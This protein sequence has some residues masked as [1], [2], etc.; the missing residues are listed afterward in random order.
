MDFVL[1]ADVI[2][3]AVIV[4][5]LVAGLILA[6]VIVVVE[7]LVLRL[8]RWAPLGRSFAD[9]VVANVVSAVVGVALAIVL[10]AFLAAVVEATAA[11]I[12]VEMFILSTAI[13]AG[14]IALI[15]RRPMRQVVGP[16]AAANGASHLLL[17]ALALAVGS[18]GG[19]R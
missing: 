9:S 5:T 6:L 18:A 17:L 12:V 16:F 8:V 14:V 19:W 3:G 1:R 13:E 2:S 10:P 15:R 4:A 11:L 7:G